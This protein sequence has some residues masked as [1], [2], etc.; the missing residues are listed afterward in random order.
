MPVTALVG[1][2]LHNEVMI[3]VKRMEAFA[4][5]RRGTPTDA[6]HDQISLRP[7]VRAFAPVASSIVGRN[8]S[9]SVLARGSRRQRILREHTLHSRTRVAHPN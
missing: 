7:R 5:R 4:A 1:Q 8:K 9:K 3:L 2:S 6:H